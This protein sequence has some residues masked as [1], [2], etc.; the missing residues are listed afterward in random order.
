[1][2][3]SSKEF[4]DIQAT[5]EC[6]STPKQVRDMKRTYRQM[7]LTDKYSQL[8]WIIWLVGPNGWVFVYELRG[9]GFKSSC[10]HWNFRFLDCF[11]QVVPW[12]SINC[13]AW[14]LSEMRTWHDNNIQ[15]NVLYR[16][17]LTRHLNYLVSLAK[18]LRVRLW[19]KWFWART[20][21]QSLKLQIS[22]LFG[23][24][25]SLRFRQL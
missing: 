11:G 12:H 8:G 14:I 16:K 4:L 24:S 5:I 21:L 20:Q 19:T 23:A 6:R 22:C 2:P 18:W 17:V 25:I 7:H 1:M 9:L 15:S 13:R 3:V 10:G